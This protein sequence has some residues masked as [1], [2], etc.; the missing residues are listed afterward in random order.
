MH[1]DDTHS[2]LTLSHVSN[3]DLWLHDRPTETR[4][5]PETASLSK[6]HTKMDDT[7]QYIPPSLKIHTVHTEIGYR[8]VLLHAFTSGIRKQ[9][10]T[11]P[12]GL[13]VCCGSTTLQGLLQFYL[14]DSLGIVCERRIFCAGV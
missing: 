9:T 3:S 13:R 10:W 6:I 5:L 14:S 7:A 1:N 11:R 12:P 8:W 2:A 4:V